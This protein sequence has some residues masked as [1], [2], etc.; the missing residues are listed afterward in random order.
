MRGNEGPT[1]LTWGLL[2]P[3]GAW[4]QPAPV[5]RRDVPPQGSFDT[6]SPLLLLPLHAHLLQASRSSQTPFLDL[7][8]PQ[9][10]SGPFTAVPADD[11][12]VQ[13]NTSA[14]QWFPVA[15]FTLRCKKEGNGEEEP[16]VQV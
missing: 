4:C 10:G 11:P 16:K 7:T 8:A 3:V 14:G 6:P 13:D 15:H 2:Y 1:Q 9:A 5:P 12:S